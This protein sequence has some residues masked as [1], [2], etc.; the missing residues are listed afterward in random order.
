[1]ARLFFAAFAL[2]VAGNGNYRTSCHVRLKSIVYAGARPVPQR[3][4][5][6]TEGADKGAARPLPITKAGHFRHAFDRLAGRLH[7]LP[8]DLLHAFDGV[9]QVS[10][11]KARSKWHQLM[12]ASSARRST[13]SGVEVHARPAKQ[14]PEAPGSS[15]A[16]SVAFAPADVK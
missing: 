10:A 1:L 14:R 9:V 4:R 5:R 16:H 13:V 7:R 3:L 11:T 6:L 12:P 2:A 15:V 8:R